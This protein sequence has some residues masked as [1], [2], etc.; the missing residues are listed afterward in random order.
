[1]NS[2]QFQEVR[3]VERVEE[4]KAKITFL[5]EEVKTLQSFRKKICES[6]IKN[7]RRVSNAIILKSQIEIYGKLKS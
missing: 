4:E 2:E 6:E 3:A 7:S 1:M 5:E